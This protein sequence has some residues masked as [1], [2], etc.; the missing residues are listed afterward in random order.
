MSLWQPANKRGAID[1]GFTM[2]DMPRNF[3][4]LNSNK[5]CGG[6]RARQNHQTLD[7]S[8]SAL[9]HPIGQKAGLATAMSGQQ[10]H[11]HSRCFHVISF[12][13]QL[14]LW[15]IFLGGR[16]VSTRPSFC[17]AQPHA[18]RNPSWFAHGIVQMVARW[19]CS[20]VPRC[21][22]GVTTANKSD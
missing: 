18:L 3:H 19:I 21:R 20:H 17:F 2:D 12:V 6:G 9:L 4:K 14:W 1:F 16:H 10:T 5:D 11:S 7:P 8:P 15:S 22:D 13:L